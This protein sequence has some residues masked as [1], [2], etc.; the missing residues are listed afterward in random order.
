[1][2][3]E[4]LPCLKNLICIIKRL[5]RNGYIVSFL[6]SRLGSNPIEASPKKEQKKIKQAAT[7]SLA[8]N[9]ASEKSVN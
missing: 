7:S 6:A 8:E 5:R 9:G 3:L 1:M 2:H 4:R